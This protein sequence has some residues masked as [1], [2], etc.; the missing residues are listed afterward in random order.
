MMSTN[1]SNSIVDPLQNLDLEPVISETQKNIFIVKALVGFEME[2]GAPNFFRPIYT[3]LSNKL[4]ET[5]NKPMIAK[6]YDFEIP[7]LGILKDNYAATIYNNLI[8]IGV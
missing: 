1:Y 2:D 4:I 7:E 6:A 8:I 5:Y 3:D